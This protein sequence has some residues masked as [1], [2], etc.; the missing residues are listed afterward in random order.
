MTEA[1]GGLQKHGLWWE[2]ENDNYLY[3][4]YYLLC[5]H[6]CCFYLLLFSSSSYISYSTV[7]IQVAYMC[8]ETVEHRV[9][10]IYISW[11]EQ[12]IPSV[13]VQAKTDATVIVMMTTFLFK[14]RGRGAG[15]QGKRCARLK[16]LSTS[17]L[18]AGLL[19]SR[20]VARASYCWCK[21]QS[22]DTHPLT[23]CRRKLVTHK[24]RD[25]FRQINLAIVLLAWQTFQTICHDTTYHAWLPCYPVPR[26]WHLRENWSKNLL[27][28]TIVLNSCNCADQIWPI[29]ALHVWGGTRI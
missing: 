1:L 12:F 7:H 2:R 14:G 13:S 19:L 10:K 26:R 9:F 20:S 28:V 11:I 4:L 5:M 25:L 17:K 18:T 23:A 16:I 21:G 8:T 22:R 3:I 15:S 27:T 29:W 24:R 6:P